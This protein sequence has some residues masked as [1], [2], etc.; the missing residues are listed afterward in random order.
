MLCERQ[1]LS[2]NPG[3]YVDIEMLICPKSVAIKVCKSLKI[4]LVSSLKVQSWQQIKIR[5]L[6]YLKHLL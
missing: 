5:D 1:Y 3:A 4:Q 6:R 2:L